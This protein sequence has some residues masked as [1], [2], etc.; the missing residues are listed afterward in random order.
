MLVVRFYGSAPSYRLG[1]GL[2]PMTSHSGTQA[3]RTARIWNTAFSWKKAQEQQGGQKL[4]MALQVSGW[5]AIYQVHSH[6]IDQV[7]NNWSRKDTLRIE[8][9]S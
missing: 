8:E 1:V 6:V 2:L 3:V 5:W 4:M 7:Q 9:G